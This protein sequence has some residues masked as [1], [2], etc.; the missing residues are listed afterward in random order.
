MEKNSNKVILSQNMPAISGD[1]LV[2]E[3]TINKDV[4]E[5]FEHNTSGKMIKNNID[6]EK[7]EK[8][9]FG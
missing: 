3:R 9:L 2:I 4:M 6:S 8:K 5:S 1:K 7:N